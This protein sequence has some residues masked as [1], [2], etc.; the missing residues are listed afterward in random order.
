LPDLLHENIRVLYVED[1]AA[2]ISLVRAGLGSGRESRFHLDSAGTLADAISKLG[3]NEYDVVLLDL[4]LPDST[5]MST[6]ASIRH[7]SPDTPLVVLSAHSFREMGV[8]AVYNGADEFLE[9]EHFDGKLLT[10]LI[11]FAIERR[12][13][14]KEVSLN[15]RHVETAEVE[16]NR[17]FEAVRQVDDLVMITD[18][19]GAIQYTNPAFERIT[20]Y[21]AEEA[22]GQTPKLLQSGVT[23]AATY[24]GMWKA[25]KS[26]KTWRGRFVNRR[27]DGNLYSQESVL[28]PIRGP[29]G[30]LVGFVGLGRDVT[31]EREVE[32]RLRQS[33]KLQ[34]L[35]QLASGVAHDFNNMLAVILTVAGIAK[36]DLETDASRVGP[37]LDEIILAARRAESVVARL[38]GFSRKAALRLQP[39]S[40][41]EVVSGMSGMIRA[42]LP[43]TIT[44]QSHIEDDLPEVL[45]DPHAVEQI[46]LN[47]VTNARDAM[48]DSG[49]LRITVEAAELDEEFARAHP[50][51]SAGAHVCISVT[52][53]GTGFDRDQQNRIFT[54]FF[55]TKP[56][57]KG[58]GL[59]L[60]LVS[61][62]MAQ[63]SG[64]V[65]AYS[66]LGMGAIFKLYF[67]SIRER[68]QHHRPD[69]PVSAL[70]AG[71]GEV[72]L[73]VEDDDALRRAA[74][75]VLGRA[76]Y[77]VRVAANGQEGLETYIAARNEI[78]V[79]VTDMVM[80]RMGGRELLAAI[81]NEGDLVPFVLTSGYLEQTHEGDQRAPPGVVY[82][83]KPWSIEDL[84]RGVRRSLDLGKDALSA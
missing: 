35:G 39:A 28:S 7:E 30:K 48:P 34:A 76:G 58:T 24:E 53:T 56:E 8:A 1:D 2:A 40:L 44:F 25:L 16:R 29:Q 61:G 46:L 64:A 13:L 9:K 42:S 82:L 27:K 31:I 73:L 36:Q 32:A 80:P 19:H 77:E 67:P 65:H 41:Q 5:G 69:I 12:R 20:G 18:G 70:T 45:A 79:I 37:D 52:D 17:L 6:L 55:T 62:L 22:V 47:L 4:G 23:P 72:V 43:S 75:R 59:G 54:P 21:S 11:M 66:E 51:A 15:R 71:A 50:G 78:D 63:H 14:L 10:R 68:R 3:S 26:G 81:R 57:G 49:E 74:R 83:P 84:L 38:L 60:A 33:Q